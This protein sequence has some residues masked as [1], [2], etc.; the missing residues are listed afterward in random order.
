MAANRSR[1]SSHSVHPSRRFEAQ[2][3]C[4]GFDGCSV[5]RL[6]LANVVAGSIEVVGLLCAFECN[7]PIMSGADKLQLQAVGNQLDVLVNN[8]EFAAA[9]I[10][11][12]KL[13]AFP[14]EN[15]R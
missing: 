6:L 12:L 4:R 13:C 8:V 9:W 5:A 1:K 11:E 14:G 2:P 10:A 7:S 3:Q 15:G